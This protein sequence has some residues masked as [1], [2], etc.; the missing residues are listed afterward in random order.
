MKKP[1]FR[2]VV[3]MCS[4]FVCILFLMGAV[5]S[6]RAA[7]KGGLLVEICKSMLVRNDGQVPSGFRIRSVDR[8]MTLKMGVKNTS[9]KDMSA[10]TVEYVALVQRW[11]FTESG[12]VER[13][14]GTKPL[15]ALPVAHDTRILLGEF[16]I[17]GHLHGP[18]ERHVDHLAAW[19][20]TI[21]R[22][23]QKLEFTSGANFESL[24]LRAQDHS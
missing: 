23:G 5:S 15:D 13:Y 8:T 21:T 11:G 6:L 16:H 20:V 24:N 7:E 19:K 14:Q 22:D 4:W 12:N 9:N 10:T 18:S 1:N 3:G 17:G 2:T